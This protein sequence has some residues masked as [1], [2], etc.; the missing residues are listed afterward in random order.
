MSRVPNKSQASLPTVPRD[1]TVLRSNIKF[2]PVKAEQ[3]HRVPGLPPKSKVPAVTSISKEAS[4]S[5]KGEEFL[6]HPQISPSSTFRGPTSTFAKPSALRMP[7]PSFGF[8]HSGKKCS[9]VTW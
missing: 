5:V 3:L 8:F 1:T 2:G 9:C 6:P 4:G 7:S